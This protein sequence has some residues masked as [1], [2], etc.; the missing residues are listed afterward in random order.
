VAPSSGRARGPPGRS[1]RAFDGLDPRG[2]AVERWMIEGLTRYEIADRRETS[3]Y[4]VSRQF[5]SIYSAFRVTGRYAL[6]RRAVELGCFHELRVAD[7][8]VEPSGRIE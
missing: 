8:G 3:V 7:A 1:N 4:T 2:T 5:H 6:I